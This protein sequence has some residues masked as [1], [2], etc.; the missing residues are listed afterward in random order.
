MHLTKVFPLLCAIAAGGPAQDTGKIHPYL[1]ERLE[2]AEPGTRVPVYFVLG[3]RL[4]YEHWFPRVHRLPLAERRALVIAE[5][6]DH[7]EQTQAEILQYLGEAEE[8][9]EAVGLVSNWVG[10]LVQVRATPAVIRAVAARTGVESVWYD[11]APPRADVEDGIAGPVRFPGSSA[12][13]SLAIGPPTPGD[14]PLAVNAHKVWDLGFRGE[15]VVVMN[16]DS[17]ISVNQ[18]DLVNRLWHNRGEIPGNGL[19]DDNNGFIDDVHGWNFEAGD[20][21][22]ND[23]GG[24]GTQVAAC[25]VGDGSCSGTVV[26]VAPDARVMSARLVGETDQWA[27]VQYAL[28]MGADILTSSHSYKLWFNPPPNYRMHREVG[29]I[30]LA[31]GLIRVNSISNDGRDCDTNLQNSKPFNIAA[32]GNLPPPYLDPNQI[33]AGKLGGV[34]GVGA[35]NWHSDSLATSSPCGP[36]AWSLADLLVRRPDYDS[37]SWKTQDHDDYLWD[38]GA[39]QGL[40]KPDI[41]GPSRVTTTA[42]IGPGCSPTVLGGTSAAAPV[43]A[44]CIALWKSA[45]PS[46]T[47][48]D[49]GM[50]VHQTA[51]DRGEVPGKENNWGAGVIDAF[52]GLKRALCVHRVNGETV[53]ELEHRVGQNISLQVDGLPSR[54]AAIAV[55]LERKTVNFG[56]LDVGIGSDG[57]IIWLGF[58]DQAGNG[59]GPPLP[60]A[61][62]ALGLK[63]Y[64]Q[65]FIADFAGVT[66]E[67]LPSNVIGILLT[68]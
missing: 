4:G 45:N 18:G 50:I 24:H 61:P 37:A 8:E 11:H 15:G 20:G 40:L 43:T 13:G 29:E 58:T 30:S 55:S 19:D 12:P 7:A 52:A 6:R 23:G 44:G 48:E 63:V 68:L 26:G 14:G 67:I 9:E 56:P 42:G 17:G 51:R 28:L 64:T 33:L 21:V 35:W 22:L 65:A 46:L 54:L 36:S 49:V 32:P 57:V 66:G 2:E 60:V 16:A 31:A 53:W 47:P 39:S 34:L 41:T 10:N 1:Q 3:D 59:G 25:I 5:L 38:G 62:D 27:A